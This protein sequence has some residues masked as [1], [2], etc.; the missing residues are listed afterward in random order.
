MAS[1]LPTWAMEKVTVGDRGRVEQA[2]RRKTLQIVWPDDKGLRR[3]AREQ[4]WPAPWFSFHERFIK[5]MLESDTNFALALSASGIG[6][7]I[8]VQRYVFSEEELH[9]LDA[10]YEERSWRWLVESLREIRRAVEADVVV[11]IDGQQLKS[12][13]SFYTWAH[14]RYHVLEDGYDPW[15]GDDRA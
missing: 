9:E 4:G 10:A 13:G 14:G 5:K 15:I 6:L 1:N 2:Y 11:E 12:F 8:P 3:W 7:M